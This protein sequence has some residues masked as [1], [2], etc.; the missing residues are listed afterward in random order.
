MQVG[1]LVKVDFY[2]FEEQ[3]HGILLEFH[4]YYNDRHGS[5]TI[6]FNDGDIETFRS[7]SFDPSEKEMTVEVLSESR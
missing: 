7:Q 6:L 3:F 4:P 5:W 2:G 1:D